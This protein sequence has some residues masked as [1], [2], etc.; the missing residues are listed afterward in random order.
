MLNEDV[1][2]VRQRLDDTISKPLIISGF[3]LLSCILLTGILVARLLEL[4]LLYRFDFLGGGFLLW[5]GLLR[6]A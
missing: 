2:G 3:T 4:W 6:S 1:W 5:D